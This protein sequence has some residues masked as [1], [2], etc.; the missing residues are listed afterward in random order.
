MTKPRLLVDVVA[1][2]VC[3]WCFV[4]LNSFLGAAEA[5]APDFVVAPRFRAYQL[6]PDTPFDGVDREAYYAR[7]FPDP[8]QRAAMRARL[9]DAARG[10]G[11]DF[12]PTTPKRLPNTLKAHQVLRRAQFDGLQ[13]ETAK[14]LYEAYWSR[15][16]D[17]GDDDALADA[18]AQGGLD[19]AGVVEALRSGAGR[20]ETAAEAHA[21][22]TAGVSGV[23]T[24]IVNERR[25]FSGALPPA[26]LR[27]ALERAFEL[28]KESAA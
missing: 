10:A 21:M 13:I 9:V 26:E 27:S 1:D 18:A 19:R 6:N 24:F 25:G 5:L 23:P 7:K 8:G 4:G 12:D 11:A 17:L 14:A 28:S 2:F 22:R 15:G 16:A 20:A 3:P